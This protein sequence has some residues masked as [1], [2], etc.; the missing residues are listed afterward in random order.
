MEA[1]AERQTF[2]NGDELPTPAHIKSILLPLGMQGVPAKLTLEGMTSS[3]T[4]T[5]TPVTHL[6][7]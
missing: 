2:L 3:V 1:S 4:D 5:V 6:R 7:C